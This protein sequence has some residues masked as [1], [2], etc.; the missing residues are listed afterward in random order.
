MKNIFKAL[1]TATALVL[2]ASIAQA[3]EWKPTDF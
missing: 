1:T 3:G 2:T